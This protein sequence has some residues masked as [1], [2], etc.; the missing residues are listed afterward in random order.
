MS[1]VRPPLSVG[2]VCRFNKRSRFRRIYN[3]AVIVVSHVLGD[4]SDGFT[5]I[6]GHMTYEDWDCRK[7][8]SIMMNR[9]EL[10]STGYNVKSKGKEKNKTSAGKNLRYAADQAVGE[11]RNNNGRSH[12]L[13]CGTPTKSVQGFFAGS[14]YD[15]CDNPDCDWYKN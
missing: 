15:M 2:D 13:K 11:A 12:C 5:P 7:T 14:G 9:R 8:I 6:K 10:W 4:P 3:R 1:K